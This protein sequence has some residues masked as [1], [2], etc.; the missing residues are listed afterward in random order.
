M[1]CDV[2]GCRGEARYV[3]VARRNKRVCDDCL[4]GMTAASDY[5]LTVQVLPP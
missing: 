5:P 4:D 2:R 1:R 3:V